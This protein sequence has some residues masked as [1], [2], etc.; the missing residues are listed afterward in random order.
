M[1]TIDFV[2]PPRGHIEWIEDRRNGRGYVEVALQLSLQREDESDHWR[3]VEASAAEL[4]PYVMGSKQGLRCTV[5]DDWPE[6]WLHW[7]RTPQF[8]EMH[9]TDIERIADDLWNREKEED[10]WD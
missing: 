7:C 4:V 10:Q 2:Y 6:A 8:L 5:E 3:I 1:Q 9:G